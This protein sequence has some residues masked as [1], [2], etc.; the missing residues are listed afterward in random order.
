MN[1]LKGNITK[2]LFLL[3]WILYSFNLSA[4]PDTSIVVPTPE[5]TANNPVCENATLKLET[6][7]QN[8][9][10][11]HWYDP[12][13]NEISVV[14]T[15][16]V[17]DMQLSMAGQ[18][19]L[20]VEQN[21]CFSEPATIDIEVT[22]RPDTPIV[23]N[24]GPLC[25]GE[26]LILDGPKLPNTSYKWIDPFGTVISNE[27][28]ATIQNIPKELAGDYFLEITQLGCSSPLGGTEVGVIAINELPELIVSG[29]A[30]EG[31]S[32]MIR[33]PHV[34][35]ANY[36]W[37]GPNGFE[38][39][40]IDSLLFEAVTTNLAGEFTLILEAEGCKS[41][42]G[43]IEV[44]V[45]AKPSATLAGGGTLCEGD[46]LNLSFNLTGTA[47]FEFTYAVDSAREFTITTDETAYPLTVA[48]QKQVNYHLISMAD[49]NGC[50]ATVE[51]S[52]AVEV[53]A[54]PQIQLIQD[55]VCDSKNENYQIQVSVQGGTQP[56]LYQG[57]EGDLV[58]TIFTSDFLPS[59]QAYNFQIID[60]NNCQS[61]AVSG[62]YSCPCNTAVSYTHLT[63]PTT[64]YV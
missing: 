21:G 7:F 1:K 59:D 35:G 22:T 58:D 25:E 60:K 47:P 3:G 55:T 33:G 23:A 57:I 53:F 6:P 10:I 13:G 51:G 34:A 42:E 32:L 26:T 17:P 54:K 37:K 5:I 45:F 63:L 28:D 18:Y 16:S 46:S 24:N 52:A 20:I 27:E 61:I 11:F 40:N 38:S 44:E 62:V 64:P 50:P 48:P 31:D 43:K 41:P 8:Q 14:A 39:D 2:S 9:V 56:F 49:K 36:S 29:P 15:A 4:R 19:R 30:C 12:E